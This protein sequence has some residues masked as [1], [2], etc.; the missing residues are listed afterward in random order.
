M[1]H[2]E[3]HF[4]EIYRANEADLGRFLISVVRDVSLAEDL[5]QEV[6]TVAWRDRS[7]VADHPEPRA[8]L[9]MAA[10][11][12]ALGEL[13]RS[14][15]AS[16]ALVSLFSHP[17]EQVKLP[18]EAV[19]VL[20]LLE[21]NLSHAD[22]GLFLLRYSHGFTAAELARMTGKSHQAIRKRLSRARAKLADALAPTPE[23]LPPVPE[24]VLRCR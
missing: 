1:D 21:R 10:R 16:R 17:E 5:L 7:S 11:N 6:W 19:E 22:R 3:K 20:D 13:R 24:E 14:R 18:F 8:W 15:R 12:R 23:S 2:N 4:L 9:F